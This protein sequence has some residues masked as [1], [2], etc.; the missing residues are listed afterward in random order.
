MIA[1]VFMCL[2]WS[3]NW[4]QTFL[5]PTWELIHLDF[6]W[7]TLEGTAFLPE[8]KTTQ[9]ETLAKKLLVVQLTT[10]EEL[11]CFVGTLISLR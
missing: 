9:V 6:L 7:D 5:D 10:Q 1:L 4:V 2:G 3:I 11:E 8:D